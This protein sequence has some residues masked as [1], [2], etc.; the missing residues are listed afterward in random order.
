MRSYQFSGLINNLAIIECLKG[1]FFYLRRQYFFVDMPFTQTSFKQF[2][3]PLM[4]NLTLTV[5]WDFTSFIYFFIS[6]YTYY[7]IFY[8]LGRHV[9]PDERIT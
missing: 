7:L 9:T 6:F 8:V 4:N 2:H 5:T 3:E 1:I